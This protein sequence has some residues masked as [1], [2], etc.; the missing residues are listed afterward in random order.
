M[1]YNYYFLP[2]CFGSKDRKKR[3]IEEDIIKNMLATSHFAQK[4]IFVSFYY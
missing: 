3:T 4:V 1:S 2:D